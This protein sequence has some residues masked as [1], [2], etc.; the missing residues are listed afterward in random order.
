MFTV[1]YRLAVEMLDEVDVLCDD[2]GRGG[3][4]RE[5]AATG[6]D[7]VADE[8]LGCSGALEAGGGEGLDLSRREMSS[9][10]VVMTVKGGWSM[11]AVMMVMMMEEKENKSLSW[12]VDASRE[13]LVAMRLA[14][15]QQDHQSEALIHVTKR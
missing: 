13:I 12:D 15:G 8:R 2:T 11:S 4:S 6:A 9:L 5:R 1:P 14:I 3:G 10:A 7:V